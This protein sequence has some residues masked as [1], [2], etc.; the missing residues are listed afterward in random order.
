MSGGGQKK[1]KKTL[2]GEARVPGQRGFT[3]S[4]REPD[5]ATLLLEKEKHWGCSKNMVHES[6]SLKQNTLVDKTCID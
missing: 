4:H 6:I 2:A 3:E 1:K 5:A